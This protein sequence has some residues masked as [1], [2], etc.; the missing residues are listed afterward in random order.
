MDLKIY[1]DTDEDLRLSRKGNLYY[2]LYLYLYFYLYLYLYL[3]VYLYLYLYSL[4][5]RDVCVKK[6]DIK[7]VIHKYMK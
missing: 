5:Y 2:Y 4:V 3:Y 6:K 7:E 1:L